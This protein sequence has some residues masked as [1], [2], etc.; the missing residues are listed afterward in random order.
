VR[1]DVIYADSYD[2]GIVLCIFINVALKIVSF[3]RAT[4]GEVFGLEVKHN[5]LALEFI[6]RH[7]RSLLVRQ[8][9]SGGF[10]TRRRW[11]SRIRRDRRKGSQ[12]QD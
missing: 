1:I 3:D 5:P 11:L 4:R 9:E 12:D 8:G 6:E 2:H 7:L 10:V